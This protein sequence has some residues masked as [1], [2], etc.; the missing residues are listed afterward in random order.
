M[1]VVRY[2]LL[3]EHNV[4]IEGTLNNCPLTFTV[5]TDAVAKPL[6]SVL[7]L[8]A[9]GSTV[10]VT[11][12]AEDFF[13]KFGCPVYPSSILTL[14][15]E[16]LSSTKPTSPCNVTLAADCKERGNALIQ[17]NPGEAKYMYTIGLQVL[18]HTQDSLL[19][20]LLLNA[21]MCDL[22]S[23]DVLGSLYKCLWVLRLEPDN[24]KAHY[25]CGQAYEEFKQLS[26]ALWHYNRSGELQPNNT[27]DKKKKA[28][29]DT[30]TKQ[31]QSK[32]LFQGIF[33]KPGEDFK[34]N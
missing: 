30:L 13:G 16:L 26:A 1:S 20:P 23:T 8:I 10:S 34:I 24:A 9:V 31:K 17:T 21:A 3:D 29:Q 7:P 28:L 6:S 2:E 27:T 5:G 11:V 15:I 14:V 33:K 22:Q 25:R 18:L 4:R 12:C 32:S 19:I